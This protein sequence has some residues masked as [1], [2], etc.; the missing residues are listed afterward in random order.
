MTTPLST[1]ILIGIF[2]V[3]GT[4]HLVRPDFYEPIMPGWVPAH[5]EV[6]LGSGILE[7]VCAVGLVSPQTRRAAGWLSTAVLLGVFPANIKMAV[8]SLDTDNAGLQAAAFGRLPLQ[9]P[10]VWAGL[11]AARAKDDAGRTQ[12]P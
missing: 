5:R 11:R 7:L 1:K 2:A 9:I 10:L 6:I 8:D 12:A 4:V 3:S